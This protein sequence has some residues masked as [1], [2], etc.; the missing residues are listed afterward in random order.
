MTRPDLTA[1]LRTQIKRDASEAWDNND[2]SFTDTL[3]DA[4]Y[5]AGAA[6][7]SVSASE[8]HPQGQVPREPTE[9]M[10]QFGLHH[11]STKQHGPWR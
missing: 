2:N 8:P 3:I 7:A 11:Q 4:A 1:E 9:A 6:A 5:A 10:L